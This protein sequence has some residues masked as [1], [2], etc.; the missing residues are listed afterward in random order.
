MN[1]KIYASGASSPELGYAITSVAVVASA[2]V[3]K[4]ALPNEEPTDVAAEP[5]GARRVWWS[6]L[7]D[8][9][10]TPIYEQDDVRAGQSVVGPAI[11]EAPSTTLAVPPGRV[12]ELDRHRIFHLHEVGRD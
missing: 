4:P 6:E 3:E 7:G 10:E 8:G 5:K 12:A 11:I 1:P 9:V 2:P